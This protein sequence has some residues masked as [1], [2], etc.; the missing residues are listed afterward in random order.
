MFAYAGKFGVPCQN[1]CCSNYT[2]K[3]ILEEV[4]L[5][6]TE[7]LPEI[8]L[9]NITIFSDTGRNTCGLVMSNLMIKNETKSK[10]Y[11]NVRIDSQVI[12]ADKNLINKFRSEDQTLT[13]IPVCAGVF[14]SFVKFNN[15][16]ILFLEDVQIYITRVYHHNCN[17][18]LSYN[19]IIDD[20]LIL[21]MQV[22][23]IGVSTCN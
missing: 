15:Q 5:L 7:N 18:T 11:N 22:N 14:N 2:K 12:L 23:S 6:L 10:K 19:N 1:S 21:N 3:K 17:I 13:S 20:D 8:N 9:D 16:K 4:D